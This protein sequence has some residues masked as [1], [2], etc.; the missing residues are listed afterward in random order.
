MPSIECLEKYED[1]PIKIKDD[2]NVAMSSLQILSG[3]V[4]NIMDYA[5]IMTKKLKLN[6][7]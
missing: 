5:L 1:L 7:E 3:I 4:N 6:Y 2:L